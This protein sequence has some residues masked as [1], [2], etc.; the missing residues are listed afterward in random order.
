MNDFQ[1]E[2]LGEWFD[3]QDFNSLEELMFKAYK[4]FPH[5]DDCGFILHLYMEMVSSR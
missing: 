4:E 1:K 2:Y 5:F 3:L